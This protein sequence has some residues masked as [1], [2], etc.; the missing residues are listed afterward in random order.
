MTIHAYGVWVGLPTRYNAQT[1]RDNDRSPHIYLRFRDDNDS[2]K[3]REAAINVKSL[4]RDS[5]LVFWKDENFSHSITTELEK[6]SLGFQ[7]ITQ[8]LSTRFSRFNN[9]RFRLLGGDGDDDDNGTD[10]SDTVAIDGL[11]FIRTKSLLPGGLAAGLVVPFDVPAPQDDILREVEPVLQSA[12]EQGATTYIFGSSF[13]S[14]IHDIH[15][16]QGSN[17]KFENGAGEDGAL[18]IRY[19]SGTWTAVFIAF[20]SQRIPTDD[21]T[22]VPLQGSRSLADILG[23]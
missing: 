16:N 21:T 4:D 2:N 6:L 23:Q 9:P 14:G 20:A 13:G 15:M 18:L 17:P 1:A 7:L 19:P 11:D 22:G 3:E 12:I 5:R 8:T 10:N